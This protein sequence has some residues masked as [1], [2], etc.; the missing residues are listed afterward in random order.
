MKIL[1]K[2]DQLRIAEEL[3]SV[4]R[5]LVK[6]DGSSV[7]DW[8]KTVAQACKINTDFLIALAGPRLIDEAFRL[9]REPYEL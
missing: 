5:M 2:K 6:T 4:N 7:G 3:I 9:A 8:A 1:R